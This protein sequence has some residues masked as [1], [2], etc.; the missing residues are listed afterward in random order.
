MKKKSEKKKVVVI[1]GGNGTATMLQAL[2]PNTDIDLSAVVAMSDA[3]GS[4]GKLRRELNV[5]PPG[6]ILRATLALSPHPYQILRQVFYKNRFS[7]VDGLD[8]HNIGNIFLAFAAKYGGGFM[9][10]LRA[11][12]QAVGAVGWAYP[13]TLDTVELVARMS[14]GS[15]LRGEDSIDKPSGGRTLR[16]VGAE[17]E[18]KGNIY[19]EARRA[20]EAADHVFMAPGSLYT[21]VVAALL[22]GGVREAISNSRAKI[23]HVVA[24]CYELDGELG[25]TALSDFVL[26]AERYLPKPAD[27]VL[28]NDAEPSDALRDAYLSRGWGLIQDDADKIKG[29]TVLGRD[30]EDSGGGYSV[31]KLTDILAEI[32]G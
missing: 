24:R 25:P 20:I 2:K 7:N 1:G 9:P 6:D 17:L 3:G 8:G 5:P 10:A 30:F 11:L 22:P 29:R 23:I 13:A 15:E 32:I 4:S 27:I 12:H 26:E 16:I 31:Q 21:S 18:P 19:D 14:D 28:Y